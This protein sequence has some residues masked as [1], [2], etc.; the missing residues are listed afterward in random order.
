MYAVIKTGGK[1]Y[2]VENGDIIEVEKLTADAGSTIS[3]S[4]VLMFNDDKSSKV[5]TPVLEGAAVSAEVL[6]QA[7]G[8]K[9]IVFKKKRRKGYRR[10]IGHRQ[11]LTVLRITDVT[12]KSKVT[13][14][15]VAK[16]ATDDKQ[17]DKKVS[18]AEVS[19]SKP[20]AAKKTT[21]EEKKATEKKPA[22]KK[23]A[24]KKAA[25]KKP[26]A[27]KAAAKKPLAKKAAAKKPAAKKPAAESGDQE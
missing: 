5:G 6:E 8:D 20:K 27:K 10:T 22:A 23:A 11:D 2:R 13:P 25:A 12:G 17:D 16:A 3:L 14:E 15:L 7:R 9:I 18:K 26:V 1:Q 4:P 21:S 19:K 24:A